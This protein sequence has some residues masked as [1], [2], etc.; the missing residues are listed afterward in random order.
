MSYG[1]QLRV[2][3]TFLRRS[4]D[5]VAV[6]DGVAFLASSKHSLN[7]FNSE[8]INSTDAVLRSNPMMKLVAPAR[9]YGAKS[10]VVTDPATIIGGM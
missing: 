5:I 9:I 4:L 8:R 10:A 1:G 7:F 3:V 6:D 2:L